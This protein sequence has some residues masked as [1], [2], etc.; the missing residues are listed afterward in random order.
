[1]SIQFYLCRYKFENDF[2]YVPI[3][4]SK[5]SSTF[6]LLAP[7][8]PYAPCHYSRLDVSIGYQLFG[9]PI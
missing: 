6:Y 7:L 1:M 8:R 2:I 4:N 9:T 5:D 3:K